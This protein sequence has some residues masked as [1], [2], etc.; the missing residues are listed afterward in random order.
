MRTLFLAGGIL[1][2]ASFAAPALADSS[3]REVQ[4]AVDAY[5]ATAKGA[6]FV[7]KD[8][9]ALKMLLEV[10]LLEKAVYEVCYELNNR[11]DWIHIPMRGITRI[12][13]GGQHS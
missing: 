7:P 8:E 4:S 6:S 3:S 5:L 9:K 10:Y 13:D 11:P 1:A 12:L 2:L